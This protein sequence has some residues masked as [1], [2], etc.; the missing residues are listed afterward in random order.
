MLTKK[1]LEQI[2][3]YIAINFRE[4]KP[5]KKISRPLEPARVTCCVQYMIIAPAGL[6]NRLQ[7]LEETFPQYLLN[8]IA[9]RGLNEVDVYKRA[10]L[11]RRIFS[12]LRTQKDY[13]PR[14]RTIVAIAFAMELDFDEAQD[15]L[16]RGGYALSEYSKEDVIISFFF[17]NRIYDFFQLNEVLDHYGFKPLSC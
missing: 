6:E 1:F 13:M 5:K 9:K 3:S 16:E 7:R 11:D 14:K 15:L 10:H 4:R 2:E 12:K 8:L 17:E